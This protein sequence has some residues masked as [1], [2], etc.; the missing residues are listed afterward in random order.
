MKSRIKL[1]ILNIVIMPIAN[2]YIQNKHI[3]RDKLEELAGKWA[4]ELHIDVKDICLNVLTDFIQV[5]KQ[6][7]VMV[8]LFLPSIWSRHDVKTI[9]KTLLELLMSYFKIE[10]SKVFLLTSIIQPG[11]V[12]ENG[13]IV[14]W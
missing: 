12:L 2:C 6:Y 3:S 14:E 7:E 5:G 4:E 9:Q 10:S 1:C 13:E 11:H 8:N